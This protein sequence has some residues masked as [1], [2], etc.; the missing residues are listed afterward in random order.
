MNRSG[1]TI[2]VH[3]REK[4]AV[5]NVEEIYKGAQPKARA[6]LQLA[7]MILHTSALLLAQ[8]LTTTAQ[9]ITPIAASGTTILS[10]SST[11][12]LTAQSGGL[13]AIT[14]SIPVT[15]SRYNDNRYVDGEQ[16][17]FPTDATVTVVSNCGTDSSAAAPRVTW[18]YSTGGS[19][20]ISLDV[21]SPSTF[22]SE[23]ASYAAEW[24]WLNWDCDVY[25]TP[26]PFPSSVFSGSPTG[27]GQV[28]S[29]TS[30]GQSQTLTEY[31]E[32]QAATE[33]TSEDKPFEEEE[34]ESTSAGSRVVVLGTVVLGAVA[35]MILGREELSVNNR[36]VGVG[37]YAV[38]AL[39]LSSI[40]P[41]SLVNKSSATNHASSRHLQTQ[42]IY[43]V[44]ILLDA[45][46]HPLSITAPAAR[47]ISAQLTNTD[48][49]QGSDDPC[50][51][52]YTAVITFPT[53]GATE[54][55]VSGGSVEVD[56]LSYSE[57][58]RPTDGRPFVSDG[59]SLIARPLV[60]A[61][62]DGGLSSVS[63]WAGVG[64]DRQCN[65][66]SVL[67]KNTTIQHELRHSLGEEWT[68][69]ALGEHASI[70]SFSAF[71]IALMTNAAPSKL[72]EDALVAGLDEIRHAR[73]SF[74]IASKLLGREVQPGPLPESRHE[75]GQD[76]TQFAL[77]AAREGCVDETLSA[78]A[79]AVE[80][81]ELSAA[82]N[83][84]LTS[85]K[86]AGL[87][88]STATW[89]RDEMNTI[90]MEE[91]SHSALAWRTLKWVCS[92]DEEACDAVKRAVLDENNL[93]LRFNY[94]FSNAFADKP[95]AL[96]EMKSAWRKVTDALSSVS[97]DGANVYQSFCSR[98]AA[99]IDDSSLLSELTDSILRGVFCNGASP[100]WVQM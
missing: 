87:D 86:Y 13:V 34:Y 57:C 37:K 74:E 61:S 54:L 39:A 15:V 29:I 40:I 24:R 35:I 1:T 69:R 96:A 73:T 92:V 66:E 91:A 60:G 33:G 67:D 17:V 71:S 89:I 38:A 55:D 5:K 93:E 23:A 28:V 18:D 46:T 22:L 95:E 45:C 77:A 90:A 21:S 48:S 94:R 64:T 100:N 98:K 88:A 62:C 84:G 36:F 30:N 53:S 44:E 70:A 81:S 26:A 42:C 41:K 12:L 4:A 68:K 49:Q 7:T 65:V 63:D 52:E 43:N 72:V 10:T 27:A 85:G 79:A 80:S 2:F 82:L 8:A 75:F 97:M 59:E 6:F 56:A 9:T 78:I 99:V 16:P 50:L 76:M 31:K 32:D 19:V 25:P 51:Y 58:I 14:S 11:N 3:L 47:T 20:D 83:D